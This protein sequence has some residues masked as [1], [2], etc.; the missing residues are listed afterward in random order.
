M[1][2]LTFHPEVHLPHFQEKKESLRQKALCNEIVLLLECQ[3]YNKNN[4]LMI[5][6]F[7]SMNLYPDSVV[8]SVYQM[9]QVPYL[10]LR[11]GGTHS[12]SVF[13]LFMCCVLFFPESNS[14][15]E[16]YSHASWYGSF[17]HFLEDVAFDHCDYNKVH[18]NMK[19]HIR[20]RAGL[21]GGLPA[22]IPYAFIHGVCCHIL[23]EK[24]P[25]ETLNEVVIRCTLLDRE[26][27][28]AENIV[29]ACK[30]REEY[31]D[32]PIH[33]TIGAGH[34]MPYLNERQIGELGLDLFFKGYHEKIKEN[35]LLDRLQK[36][37]IEYDIVV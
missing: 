3:E 10:T 19:I 16:S 5:N 6:G 35:R 32:K 13:V 11:E 14:F 30:E 37:S 1:V 23:H 21:R 31:S 17:T 27:K 33:V 12:I 29:H 9:S 7:E 22:D 20:K 36:M 4:P 8:C 15:F 26:E 24:Y 25:E 18:E 28:M 2:R 34:L